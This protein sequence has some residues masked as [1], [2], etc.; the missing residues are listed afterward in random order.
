MDPRQFG[1]EM[2]EDPISDSSSES[3][4]DR[5][6]AVGVLV[7]G[8]HQVLSLL[9][10]GGMGAVYKVYDRDLDRICALKWVPAYVSSAASADH[11]R[12]EFRFIA[13]IRHPNVVRVYD[14]GVTAAGDAWITMELLDG[15]PLRAAWDPEHPERLVRIA[16]DL[17]AALAHIHDRGIVH[18]DIKPQNILI[19]RDKSE[20]GYTP[21]LLDFGL[22]ATAGA[23]IDRPA[24]TLAYMAPE[25]LR[26]HAGA[27][28]SDLFGL[29][30]VLYEAVCGDPPF[31]MG[32]TAVDVVRSVLERDPAPLNTRCAGVSPRLSEIVARLLEKEPSL[33][34]HDAAEVAAELEALATGRQEL[35][36]DAT[37]GTIGGA[38]LVGRERALAELTT[39]W[40]RAAHGPGQVAAIIG[41]EGVGKTRLLEE[42]AVHVQLDGGRVITVACEE[43]AAIQ[44]SRPVL[45]L[46]R[47]AGASAPHAVLG[48]LGTGTSATESVGRQ[49]SA[50]AASL[51]A[52]IAA[53]LLIVVEDL[54]AAPAEIQ[55]LFRLLALELRSDRVLTCLTMR[56]EAAQET[57]G[58][59]PVA[60][61]FEALDG[62]NGVLVH[63]LERL[64][65]T[66]TGLLVRRLVGGI[67]GEE[68]L[69]ARVW[70]ETDGNPLLVE[71]AL[72]SL[73]DEGVLRRRAGRFVLTAQPAQLESIPLLPRGSVREALLR[74]I[75]LLDPDVLH[76]LE[77]AAVDGGPT[78]VDALA[79]AARIP[80]DAVIAALRVAERRGLMRRIDEEGRAGLF[81][82]SQA[83]V[84]EVVYRQM[85]R[86]DRRRLHRA[87]GQR[88]ARTSGMA[89]AEAVAHHFLL[90]RMTRR[91]L[92]W[93]I[94][95]G[96][97]LQSQLVPSR[98]ADL[99]LAAL[100]LTGDRA[101][102]R[103]LRLSLLERI[104]D[105]EVHL[106]RL[107][108]AI[109][110]FSQALTMPL[111][112]PATRRG[113]ALPLTIARLRRKQGDA[114]AR[115][116]K[117]E[118]ARAA[119]A[120]AATVIDTPGT[121]IERLEIRYATAWCRMMQAEYGEAIDE[122]IAGREQSLSLGATAMQARFDLLLANL[123]WNCGEWASST[124]SARDALRLF[125]ALDDRRGIADA[126]LALGTAHRYKAE[127]PKAATNYSMALAIYEELGVIAYV[128]KCQNNLGVVSYL[129]GRWV[130]AARHWEAFVDVCE[131]TGERNE[132]IML[133]NNLGVLYSDRAELERAEATLQ[134]GL[135]LAR[136]IGFA[137]IEAML[138]ANLGEVRVRK[139]HFSEAEECYRRCESIA[140]E[141]DARDELVE[142]AR[143]RCELDLERNDTVRVRL[144][145]DEAL[146]AASAL[147]ARIEEAA[148]FRVRAVVRR[149]IGDHAAAE[150][151]LDRAAEISATVGA[152]LEQQRV[153]VER[154]MQLA[155]KGHYDEARAKLRDAIDG[156][157][158]LGA[159][160]EVRR[161]ET[162]LMGIEKLTSDPTSADL[163]R[164]LDINRK[165]G[166]ILDLDDLL[167]SIIDVVIEIT[168]FERAFIIVYEAD[169]TPF[170][171]VVRDTGSAVDDR[172]V[173][174]S[175]SVTERV[176]RTGQAIC[177]S[178][179]DTDASFPPTDSVVALD[180]RSIL[181]VPM[182]SKGATIGVIY[183]DSRRI[184]S[185]PLA[186]AQPMLE[187]LGFQAAVAIENARLYEMERLRSDTI[188][189][190]AH[191]LKSPMTAILGYL[192]IMQRQEASLDPDMRDY[193]RIVVDQSQRL[194]R[195]VRNILDL[196][197][198]ENGASAWSMAA[199]P[200]SELIRTSLEAVIP[201]A[202]IQGIAVV[203]ESLPHGFEVFCSRDRVQ[204]VITNLVA[205][206]V[207]FTPRG[208]QITLSAEAVRIEH[209]DASAPD[210]SRELGP[211]VPPPHMAEFGRAAPFL[212]KE[213]C[214]RIGVRDT[215]AG[216]PA[217]DAR[218]IFE[219]YAQGSGER[220][221]D[222][223]IGL[224]LSIAREIVL[225]HG[226]R[227][228][229]DSAPGE[230]SVFFF[231]LPL[232]ERPGLLR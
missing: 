27:A 89:A 176:Y 125:R 131:R 204:Q 149:R 114:L 215:G 230:G 119:L 222:R 19:V 56:R 101:G 83:A 129:R 57:P 126:Y 186:R 59:V 55:D 146:Q 86:G 213:V 177:V 1:P 144:R 93:A 143:R 15:E 60:D 178:D 58:A 35:T 87:A 219:K 117:Y 136:R 160:W 133:L 49:V 52:S 162:A 161:A 132:R 81:S 229:V 31:A 33:R 67:P 73:V 158:E 17:S 122:V 95:A 170:V 211:A 148:L 205:N 152:S 141:I 138:E 180:L 223:G 189:T 202:D 66:D 92:R 6:L 61:R 91:A 80:S 78:T 18:R 153:M 150:A 71:E 82:F 10:R 39:R 8:R 72:R 9:G 118:E 165:L 139:G 11:V 84:R 74:R 44:Q 226:G 63:T 5:M 111:Q 54:H 212:S 90:G 191:E 210:A 200:A 26:G 37:P 179:V 193:L 104:G 116:G 32:P 171:K 48:E 96:V 2:P 134:Q 53:P 24:G 194:T 184:A 140:T 108:G 207:K 4:G 102:A 163:A 220:R 28:R 29:G 208:G 36:G 25:V 85:N 188:A 185:Q 209:S 69:R 225:R 30:A 155:Q 154:S 183:T 166:T 127:Y 105:I 135:S 121:L 167:R 20:H 157:R 123:Y 62:E 112:S 34:Y 3:H 145:V 97:A 23:R 192:S 128:G 68:V 172:D 21:K 228:W 232:I 198:I 40:H 173:R 50:V 100:P 214:L 181:C 224:G 77:V 38:A 137:R 164:L 120:Q 110:T 195:M 99:F 130:D 51:R 65:Q 218:R 22:A 109:G 168:G 199:L 103:S 13:G 231:T 169:G 227:I 47:R 182:Q 187:A 151:D 113:E 124:V 98:A 107:E 12:S 42:L 46:L 79:V 16:A 206:A 7:D 175:R 142:L 174:I 41:E 43:Q 217:A 70:K 201:I 94:R 75:R 115:L 106:G 147:G 88:M 190:V 159:L 196:R 203:S 14:Y 216:I 221:G 156:L 197:A 76:V 64:G 45:Q